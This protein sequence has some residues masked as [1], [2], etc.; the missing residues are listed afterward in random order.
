MIFTLSRISTNAHQIAVVAIA[1]ARD[2]NLEVDLG[3][4]VV[5]LR[6]AQIPR[7]AGGA[8]RRTGESPGQRLLGRHHADIDGALLP[9]AV[10][11]QQV[12]QIVDEF[13][14]R[15]GPFGDPLGQP[16]RQILITPPGRK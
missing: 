15:L 4:F 3:V 1:V 8:Q 13:R 7:H 12:F 6:P 10:A 2:R 14:K 16:G 5:G 9:D 11:G